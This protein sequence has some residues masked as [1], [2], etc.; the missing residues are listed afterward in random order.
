M[1]RLNHALPYWRYAPDASP[2]LLRFASS[3]CELLI[4]GA[5]T[6]PIPQDQ[7][8][9]RVIHLPPLSHTGRT[10]LWR[11]LTS[12]P[13]PTQVASWSLT[14]LEIVRA[15]NAAPAGEEALVDALRRP[16][17]IEAEEL[18]QV[19]PCPYTW[20]DI[21]LAPAVRTALGEFEQQARLR[22]EVY[23]QWGFGD[24]VPLGR[25]VSAL[26]AGP[27]GTGKT[28]AAQ[29]LARSLKMDL[30][31]VD[32][33]TVVNKYIGETEKR[34][35]HLF[36]QKNPNVILFFDEADA[37]FGQRTQVKGRA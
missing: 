24:L 8:V 28:M 22:W 10:S 23:E 2:D 18:A 30:L 34:L 37:L 32:L 13:I 26:F 19:L 29:V 31:R 33:A 14:P 27:S 25:G 9:M 17:G 3:Y 20:A 36:D 12:Y 16:M 5:E 6:A 4:L 1:A 21:V 11:S 7:T 15:A 35:K